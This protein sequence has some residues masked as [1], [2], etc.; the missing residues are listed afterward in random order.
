MEGMLRPTTLVTPTTDRNGEAARTTTMATS[1]PDRRKTAHRA[2]VETHRGED[3][4]RPE[5][6]GGERSPW[7]ERATA[8]WQRRRSQRTRQRSKASRSRVAE[9]DTGNGV[10]RGGTTTRGQRPQRCGTAAEGGTS[11]RGV[12]AQSGKRPNDQ[13]SIARQIYQ[14]GPAFGQ[15]RSGRRTRKRCE[16]LPVPGCNRP[17]TH[18]RRKPSG[19]CETTRAERVDRIGIRSIEGGGNVIGSGR[20]GGMSEEGTPSSESHERQAR[21]EQAT[22][23]R[24]LRIGSGAL[25]AR[26]RSRGTLPNRSHEQDRGARARQRP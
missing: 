20:E 22:A 13:T 5:N 11:S 26:R 8:R 24:A 4:N 1:R 25:K 17:G 15:R 6:P 18:S 7:K 14:V 19:W 23:R 10:P 16:P 12:K 2:G 9:Q 21:T 3:R